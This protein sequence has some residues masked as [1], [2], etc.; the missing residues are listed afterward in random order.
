MRPPAVISW[1]SLPIHLPKNMLVDRILPAK[2]WYC[3]MAQ[4]GANDY[5]ALYK[6]RYVGWKTTD[7]FEDLLIF[8]T[9][10]LRIGARVGDIDSAANVTFGEFKGLYTKLAKMLMKNDFRYRSKHQRPFG[11]AFLDFE[12]TRMGG[13]IRQSELSGP[14]VHCVLMVHPSYRQAMDELLLSPAR[15]RIAD[16][17]PRVGSVLLEK[18]DP[19][20]RS[21]KDLISYASKFVHRSQTDHWRIYPE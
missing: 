1:L 9:L 15:D 5:L 8:S 19:A 20:R 13:S 21:V 18:Y 3:Q 6:E 2:V 10:K 16:D 11:L 14:H 12:G 4:A 17:W 7:A